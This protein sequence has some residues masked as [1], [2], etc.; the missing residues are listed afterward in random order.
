MSK[1]ASTKGA[2]SATIA[3]IEGRATKSPEPIKKTSR[4]QGAKAPKP[5][6]VDRERLTLWLARSDF[7]LLEKEQLRRRAAG[8]KR[9]DVT[10]AA[11][12]AEAIR[13]TYGTRS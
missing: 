4:R 9:G 13:K 1:R 7:A 8:A 5:P 12:I 10:L 6:P 2:L 11:L 3:A